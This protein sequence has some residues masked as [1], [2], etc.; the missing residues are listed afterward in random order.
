MYLILFY[1]L[2]VIL[3]VA[4]IYFKK[5]DTFVGGNTTSSQ[6]STTSSQL[7][8]TSS[9]LSTTSSSYPTMEVIDFSVL[10]ILEKTGRDKKS[11]EFNK[12]LSNY[13]GTPVKPLRDVTELMYSIGDCSDTIFDYTG[14]S[15]KNRKFVDQLS[16]W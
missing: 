2:A 11:V 16:F 8:T 5:M 1:L 7:S 15:D 6:L 4:L 14:Y 9:Q 3:V 10:D 13:R 12:C